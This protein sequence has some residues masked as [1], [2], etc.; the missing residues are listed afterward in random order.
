M[1]TFRV[2]SSGSGKEKKA[3]EASRRNVWIWRYKVGDV[4]C[5]LTR[6]SEVILAC[7]PSG[8]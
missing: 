7:R 3:T 2:R 5:S 8:G 1:T 6:P 4:G